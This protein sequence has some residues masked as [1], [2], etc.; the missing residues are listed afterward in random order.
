MAKRPTTKRPARKP[1]AGKHPA[2]S[3]TRAARPRGFWRILLHWAAVTC[4]WGLLALAG[5]V[6]WYVLDLPDPDML[7]RER[8]GSVTVLA[9]DGAVLAT[10]GELHG[11]AL[12]YDDL[13]PALV[14][15]VLLTPILYRFLMQLPDAPPCSGVFGELAALLSEMRKGPAAKEA[16]GTQVA[17]RGV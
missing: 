11:A 4:I 1:A 10:Y 9:A 6:G 13:P 14:Q 12:H 3:R 8:Q 5:L 16:E 7:A 15:A 2:P 17:K